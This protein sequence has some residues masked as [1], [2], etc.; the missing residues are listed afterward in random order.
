MPVNTDVIFNSLF[1]IAAFDMIPTDQF[2]DG[3]L[4]MLGSG[5]ATDSL[6]NRMER[7]GFETIW[8]LPNMGSLLLFLGLYPLMITLWLIYKIGAKCGSVKMY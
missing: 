8:I 5:N 6:A 2:Y 7:L 1:E 3:M 4:A